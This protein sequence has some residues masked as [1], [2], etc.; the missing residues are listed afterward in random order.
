MGVVYSNLEYL[1]IGLSWQSLGLVYM[2]GGRQEKQM[3]ITGNEAVAKSIANTIR[4]TSSVPL[5]RDDESRTEAIERELIKLGSEVMRLILRVIF[6]AASLIPLSSLSIFLLFSVSSS[7][8]YR[9]V[10][11]W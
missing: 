9:P 1:V 5:N 11:S 3:V 10:W 7:L 2:V 4:I 8:P 6:N